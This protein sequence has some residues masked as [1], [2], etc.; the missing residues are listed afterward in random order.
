MVIRLILTG[1]YYKILGIA[2]NATAQEIKKAYRRLAFKYHPD[3]NHEPEAEENFKKINEAYEVL[4][5]PEKRAAYDAR[6]AS[7]AQSPVTRKPYKPNDSI[8][9]ESV[10]IIMQKGTPRWAK[11]LAGAGLILAVYLKTKK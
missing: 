5:N 1:D 4:T 11:V 9:E 2:R 3:H 8:V 10:R 6:L 7:Y